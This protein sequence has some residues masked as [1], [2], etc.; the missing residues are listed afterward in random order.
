MTKVRLPLSIE[1]ALARIAGLLEGDYQA[2][3]EICG[4]QPHTIRAWG[5]PDKQDDI[6]VGCAIA[7]DLAFQA[8]GGEGSPLYEAYGAKLDLADA[9]RF[10]DTHRLLDYAQGVIKEGGEAH[11]AIIGAARKDATHNEKRIAFREASE[12][13]EKLRDIL[14]LLEAGAAVP[15]ESTEGE[16]TMAQAP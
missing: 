6:P 5:D 7:L 13:Y 9:A 4:R 15:E 1:Q 10:A 2:M 14:P 16:T 12:A 11:A 8:A 3:G